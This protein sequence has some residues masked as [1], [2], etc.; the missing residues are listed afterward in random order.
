MAVLR[1]IVLVTVLA[2][3][4][5]WPFVHHGLV[6]RLEMNPWKLA[7]W[8][9]Y[10]EPVLPVL[11]AIFEPREEGFAYLAESGLPREAVAAL[12]DFRVRRRELGTLVPPDGL[13]NEVLQARQDLFTLVVLVQ[14][15][16]LDPETALMESVRHRYDYERDGQGGVVRVGEE[17]S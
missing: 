7:G 2:L 8:A 1:R 14:R 13:A 5:V 10:T 17:V 3:A 6:A 16:H 15:F 12:E 9:M 11:V 4:G